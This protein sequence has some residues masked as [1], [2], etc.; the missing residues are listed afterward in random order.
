[1]VLRIHFDWTMI[2]HTIQEDILN[3]VDGNTLFHP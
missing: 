1:M 3:V 2:P